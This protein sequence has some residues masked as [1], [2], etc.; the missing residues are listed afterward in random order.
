MKDQSYLVE[1]SKNSRKRICLSCDLKNEPDLIAQYI[2]YHQRENNWPEINKGIKDSGIQIMD[3][4]LVDNRMFMIC[5]VDENTDFDESWSK[6]GTFPKQKEWGELVS[7]FQQ[8][9]PGHPL[10]WVKMERVYSLPQ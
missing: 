7:N 4:Y 8:A 9:I 2:H 1:A 5:E 10:E 6:M 3:I